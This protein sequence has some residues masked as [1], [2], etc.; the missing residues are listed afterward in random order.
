MPTTT[1]GSRVRRPPSP[2]ALHFL[3]RLRVGP[4]GRPPLDVVDGQCPPAAGSV[5][6]SRIRGIL[7]GAAHSDF[8]KD[9]LAT[10]GT[11][12][13][14]LGITFSVSVIVARALG[15]EGRGLYAVAAAI[16]ALGVQF[17]NLGFHSSNTY[18]VARQRDLLP[19]LFGNALA[20]AVALGT[21]IALVAL[22][23]FVA[24][25]TW[26]PL[27]WP[28]LILA[29]ASIPFGLANL[30]FS[31][32]LLGLERIKDFNICEMLKAFFGVGAL[33]IVLVAFPVNPT[34]AYVAAL[35]A[36][37]AGA[38]I[39]VLLVL[40][41]LR[42]RPVVSVSLMVRTLPYGLK[43]YF[44]CL[45]MFLVLRVDLLMVKYLSGPL[46]AG[47][48]SIAVTM[49][50]L[51]LLVPQV[52]GTLL[53]PRLAG[54][55]HPSRRAAIARNTAILVALGMLVLSAVALPF[56][57]QLITAVYGTDFAPAAL[58]FVWLAPGII[59]L[60]VNTIVMNYFASIGMPRIT[61]YVP[62]LALV[63]NVFLNLHLIPTHGAI[64]AAI[65]SSAAC[66]LML[67]CSSIYILIHES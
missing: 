33:G 53:F 40:H 38:C 5:L 15:P 3:R 11:R 30:L 51:L 63:L 49:A 62:S 65:A 34:T 54:I 28:V 4:F 26:R 60:S 36:W 47:H 19:A 64:G 43:S 59:C 50:N 58:S 52:V 46:D 45:A 8:L 27:P 32:L 61:I 39:A 56:S 66:A 44:A 2:A 55:S 25:P 12:V 1:D 67:L 14:V 22:F 41:R 31:N 10:V 37:I 24:F 6:G 17:G 29:L 18:Y 7:S 20:V 9:T 35:T 48:Y 16:T 21:V 23:A 42:C 57:R 13:A